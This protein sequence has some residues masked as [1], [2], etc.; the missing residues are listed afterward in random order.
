MA[1]FLDLK[2]AFDTVNHKV[3]LKKLKRV[4][5]VVA[6][7]LFQNYLSDRKQLGNT[8]SN[9]EIVKCGVPQGLTLG[10]LLF[11]LYLNDMHK[12]I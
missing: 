7:R 10:P 5:K 6:H 4:N 11:L 9:L 3:L 1:V 12:P 2:K 8:C